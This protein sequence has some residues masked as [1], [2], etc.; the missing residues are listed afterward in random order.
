MTTPATPKAPAKPA[1][2]PKPRHAVGTLVRYIRPP[3][4]LGGGVVYQPGTAK[5]LE[6]YLDEIGDTFESCRIR[7][8]TTN[9]EAH[10]WALDL[11]AATLPKEPTDG[12]KPAEGKPESEADPVPALCGEG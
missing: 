2:C 7:W 12:T 5:V 6:V 1:K 8:E 3:G 11:E 10:A 9:S 4:T